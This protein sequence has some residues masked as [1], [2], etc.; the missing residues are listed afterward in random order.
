MSPRTGFLHQVY[1]YL[2]EDAQPGD[3]AQLAEEARRHLSRIPGVLRLEVGFPAGTH[4]DVVDNS[5]GVGLLVEF[6]DKE[7][8]DIYQEHPDHTH[9]IEECRSLWSRVQVYDTL[10]THG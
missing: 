10:V 2:R 3:A 5:Y 1:F 4:R 9:F 7:A 8:Q 6:A